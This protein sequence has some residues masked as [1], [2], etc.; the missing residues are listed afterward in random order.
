MKPRHPDANGWLL[1]AACFVVTL[2]IGEVM[3]SFGVF[4]KAIES[5]FGWSRGLT[6]S[7][8]TA[9]SLAAGV[10]SIFAGRLSDRHAPRRVL[11]GAAVI[12]GPAIAACSQIATLPQ[13]LVLLMLAGM[14][15]GATM[16]VPVSTVQRYFRN[17]ARSG[18][19]LGVVA[20]GIGLGALI[21][22]PLLNSVIHT[23]GWRVAFGVAGLIF[24]VL[25]GGA[26]LVIRP[27]AIVTQRTDAP[28]RSVPIPVRRLVATPQFMGIAA[29]MMAA[30]FAFQTLTV[31]IVPYATDTGITTHAAAT[32]LGLVGGFSVPGRL[33]SGFISARIGWAK[34][35]ALS[36]AACGLTIVTLPAVG[37]DRMLYLF[38]L[39]YGFSHGIRAV[40]IFGIVGRAFS[41]QALGEL[42]GIVLACGAIVGALGPIVAGR[43]F[44]VSGSYSTTFV[45]IGLLLASSALLPL[46]LRL[47]GRKAEPAQPPITPAG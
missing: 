28:Q 42:T 46:A 20:S 47:E 25:V 23:A 1:V 16:S 18:I 3:W 12:A 17:R 2:C 7:S 8:Y 33:V 38:V 5:E 14:G 6:S 41:G 10:S 29:M 19:A 35:L 39:V 40:G 34:T 4:F 22:A 11:L 15:T 30:V 26:A 21:F 32:A 36:L 45:V 31:H 43:I 27:A 44:D 37:T 13:L 24:F 9:L